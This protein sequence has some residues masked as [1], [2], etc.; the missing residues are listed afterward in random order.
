MQPVAENYKAPSKIHE[1]VVKN[2]RKEKDYVASAYSNEKGNRMRLEEVLTDKEYK[3]SLQGRELNEMRLQ[4]E[5]LVDAERASI[6][7]I[8]EL[9]ARNMELS[10][11]NENQM[12]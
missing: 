8:E 12:R 6:R 7:Q 10:I 3:I 2:L 5:R 4:N 9:K 11:D 1:E